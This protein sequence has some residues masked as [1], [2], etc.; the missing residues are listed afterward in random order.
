M[1]RA[2]EVAVFW[3]GMSKRAQDK[4]RALAAAAVAT[5]LRTRA[6]ERGACERC[7]DDPPKRGAHGV[8]EAH[9]EDYAKPLDVTWLCRR[10]HRERHREIGHRLPTPDAF[11]D[12]RTR[13]NVTVLASAPESRALV[14]SVSESVVARM[15]ERGINASA[16]AN[17]LGV[18][19]QQVSGYFRGG[20]RTM[21]ALAVIASA[22]DC[23][24][25]IHLIPKEQT[26]RAA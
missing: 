13:V 24:V 7:V 22:L 18:T 6:I 4:S 2:R 19:R 14:M 1:A 3:P 8:T 20:V 16:L 15:Q 26:R 21:K 9:H 25:R 12:L 11:D 23:D 10:H 5:A 17:R